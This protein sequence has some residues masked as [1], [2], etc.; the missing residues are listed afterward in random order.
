MNNLPD[1][2]IVIIARYDWKVYS[3]LLTLN[4]K[5]NKAI[6]NINTIN[7]WVCFTKLEEDDKEDVGWVERWRKENV[8][9]WITDDDI[10]VYRCVNSFD[11]IY[12]YVFG[13]K[14]Y[15]FNRI[16]SMY[17]G[18]RW[19]YRY[20]AFKLVNREWC[21]WSI[22]HVEYNGLVSKGEFWKV[23]APS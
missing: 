18:N 20:E 17:I 5:V 22:D 11:T 1:E 23:V 3:A 7:P 9:R 2:L 12:V 14:K 15:Q 13:E 10:E 16:P 19:C 8:K 4:K 6:G 21:D